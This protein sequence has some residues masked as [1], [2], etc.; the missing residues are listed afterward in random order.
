[1]AALATVRDT[2]ED[3][4]QDDGSFFT[5]VE[6]E[7]NVQ[8]WKIKAEQA[9][10]SDFL[11]EAEKLKHQ[12]TLIEKDRNGLLYNKKNDFRAEYSTL[13]EYEQKLTNNRRTEKMKTQQHLSKIHN[14]VKRLQ[15]QLKDVK[16][17]PEFVEKLREMMEEVDNA[18]SAFKEEQRIL[19]EDLMKE[20]KTTFIELTALEKKIEASFNNLPETSFK[21]PAKALPDAMLSSQLP[22]EVV[23]FEKF[24]QQTGGRLGGWDEY[25]H[26]S[27]LKV[28]TKHKGKPSYLEEALA[29]LPSRTKEDIQQH[30]DWY[31]ELLFLEE[32]KKEAIHKWKSRKQQEKREMSKVQ[33]KAKE[34]TEFDTQQKEEAQKQKLLEERRKRQLEVEAWKRQKEIEAAAKLEAKLKEEEEQ[35]RKQRKERQRQLEVKL[36][37]EEHTRIQKEQ[38]EFLRLEREMREEAEREE[39]RRI[40]AMEICRFQ[41]RD[42]RK[43]EEKTQEKIAKEEEVKEKEKRLAKLKEKVQVHVD[44]DPSRVCKPTKGWEERFKNIGPTGTAPLLHIPHRAVPTWRQGL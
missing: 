5:G 28:W 16:P 22:E 38:E 29:Y 41:D 2:A 1:M 20:E 34:I 13:E 43:I 19:Y 37:V 17:T 4:Q 8:N 32:K 42:Q 23:A 27:F 7:Y 24:L 35:Q 36:I 44:R 12:I 26:Q 10:K 33:E 31:Q 39:K 25:D 3:S 40:A 21:T 18:I 14:H 15:L 6:R 11:R 30:E 9:K